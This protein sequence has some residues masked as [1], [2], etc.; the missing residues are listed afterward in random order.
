MQEEI[1]ILKEWG[2][3]QGY[4]EEEIKKINELKLE[5]LEIKQ[6]EYIEEDI[7]EINE[8]E[9]KDKINME[10]NTILMLQL[11]KGFPCNGCIIHCGTWVFGD[12]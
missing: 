2:V 6:W 4:V 3:N 1:N 11:F 9:I 12:Y 10:Y 5:E 7:K 8:F